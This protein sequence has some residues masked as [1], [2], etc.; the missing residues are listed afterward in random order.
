MTQEYEEL[1]VTEFETKFTANK[2]LLI[3]I[4]SIISG[5]SLLNAKISTLGGPTEGRIFSVGD[6]VKYD[7]GDQGI[8][9]IRLFSLR[10]N[11]AKFLISR[12][13]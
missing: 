5:S 12:V 8:F 1:E 2:I 6:Y 7:A 11:I 10:N 3:S 13:K 4:G 9:E